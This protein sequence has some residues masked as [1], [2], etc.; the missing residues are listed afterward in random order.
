MDNFQMT[1]TSEGKADLRR[2]LA[3]A[4]RVTDDRPGTEARAYMIH[5]DR[6]MVLFDF[7]ER[8]ALDPEGSKYMGEELHPFPHGYTHEQALAFVS[9]W[10]ASAE[11]EEYR[12]DLLEDSDAAMVTT[13]WR[14]S[15]GK[16][17]RIGDMPHSFVAIRPVWA[18]Y[19]K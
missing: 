2:A 3:I 10:L 8:G 19:G 14:V 17:G 13:G 4:F 1:V 7:F 11:A 18:W 15:V 5:P 6:G 16:W 9:G 12:A